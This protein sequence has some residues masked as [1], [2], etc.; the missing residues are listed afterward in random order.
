MDCIARVTVR[1]AIVAFALLLASAS[2]A[3]AQTVV[4]E[5]SRPRLLMPLYT[6]H[7]TLHALD[8]HSTMQAIDNG[9]RE[10]NPILDDASP[11]Q[12]IGA[13]LAASAATVWIS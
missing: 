6:M 2:S 12:M 5:P 10:G 4:Q 1:R 3:L 7:F 11:A 13:K 9:H 8:V